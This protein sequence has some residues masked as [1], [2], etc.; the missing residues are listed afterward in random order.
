M[1]G[2][3]GDFLNVSKMVQNGK[4]GVRELIEL[5][6]ISL[7]E[8]YDAGEIEK[9]RELIENRIGYFLLNI[10]YSNR[11]ECMILV[12]G[13]SGEVTNAECYSRGMLV[14]DPGELA[15]IISSKPVGKISVSE[16]KPP[17]ITL[18]RDTNRIDELTRVRLMAYRVVE[19][20]NKLV[21]AI[22]SGNPFNPSF[23]YEE[24]NKYME[25]YI[26]EFEKASRKLGSRSNVIAKNG[27]QEINGVV[28]Q[29]DKED[30]PNT[31]AVLRKL[32]LD[33]SAFT[34]LSRIQIER[35]EAY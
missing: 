26:T 23:Y 24:I 19:T 31:I 4:V 1:Q 30:A 28:S 25:K 5:S 20:Y 13:K 33:V 3:L 32:L 10:Y 17:F 14:S 16:V 11:V 9:V 8:V 29:L 7:I 35:A 21:E 27:L 22:Y 2:S 34:A 15:R 6:E 12:K 18:E